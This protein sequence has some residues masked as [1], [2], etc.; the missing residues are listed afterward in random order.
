ME[1]CVKLPV[2][3]P[4]D[5]ITLAPVLKCLF[6]ILGQGEKGHGKYSCMTHLNYFYLQTAFE[7]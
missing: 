1:I 2:S 4:P 3:N 7:K 5:H 6:V